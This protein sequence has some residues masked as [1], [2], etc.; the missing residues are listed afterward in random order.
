MVAGL[1]I[2]KKNYEAVSEDLK[3]TLARAEASYEKIY[4]VERVDL[5]VDG[6][7]IRLRTEG[8]G[9]I[10]SELRQRPELSRAARS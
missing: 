8:M 7:L 10:V 3:K 5:D 2:G 9:S 6:V 4:A 1:T